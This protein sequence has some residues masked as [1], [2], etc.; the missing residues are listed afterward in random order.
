FRTPCRAGLSRT[1]LPGRA[2]LTPRRV[3]LN[4]RKSGWC[5]PSLMEVSAMLRVSLGRLALG[6][7]VGLALTVLPSADRPA[8]AQAQAA[9]NQERVKFDT[10]DSVELQGTFYA[11]PRGNKSPCA[12]LIHSIGENSQKEGWDELAKELQKV[13]IAVLA[14]DLRG[15]GDSTSV[16]PSF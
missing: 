3:R 14:F 15:H 7:A 6:L 11:S 13:G 9:T 4:M 12:L 2:N 16:G 8:E 1:R 5:A 10:V